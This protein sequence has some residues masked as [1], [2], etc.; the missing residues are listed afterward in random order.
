[1]WVRLV[2]WPMGKGLGTG[3]VGKVSMVAHG[4]G[5]RGRECG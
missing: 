2:R 5:V 4:E 1:M 3:S